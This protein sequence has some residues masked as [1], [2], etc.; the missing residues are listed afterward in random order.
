MAAPV[1]GLHDYVLPKTIAVR[2]GDPDAVGA[3][4]AVVRATPGE[5]GL[6]PTFRGDWSD[7]SKRALIERGYRLTDEELTRDPEV[8]GLASPSSPTEPAIGHV[9]TGGSGPDCPGPERG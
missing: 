8:L 6:D 5:E 7:E 2:I 9:R 4:L 1:G 3:D